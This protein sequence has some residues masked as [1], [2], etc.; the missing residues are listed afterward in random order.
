MKSGI[1][2]YQVEEEPTLMLN[3]FPKTGAGIKD[4]YRTVDV[5]Y[6]NIY[7]IFFYFIL[8]HHRAERR[9]S[10]NRVVNSFS[11]SLSFFSGEI[12]KIYVN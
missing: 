4:N 10:V 11:S 9:S 8:H 7:E 5:F 1:R 2:E 3:V 12:M 6:V